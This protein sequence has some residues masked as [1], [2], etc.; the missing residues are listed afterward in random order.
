MDISQEQIKHFQKEIL[1]WY[2]IHKRDLPWRRTRDPYRILISEVMSQQTQIVRVISKYETWLEAF[3]T[4]QN[5]ATAKT[6]RV[7]QLWSGLGYNRRALNLKKASEIL[8]KDY[9][10]RFPQTE[11]EL[12]T[13]PGI[14]KY[15]A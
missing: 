5:L 2:K 13:L 8:V 9:S 14:G 15:T 10:G 7:L 4:I 6:S 12:V 3:P 1:A 11:K